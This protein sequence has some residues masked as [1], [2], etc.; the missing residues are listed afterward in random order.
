MYAGLKGTEVI[1][2]PLFTAAECQT[3]LFGKPSEPSRCSAGSSTTQGPGPAWNTK[4]NN[5]T[6]TD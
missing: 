5:K 3:V 2:A 1:R 6:I 4:H